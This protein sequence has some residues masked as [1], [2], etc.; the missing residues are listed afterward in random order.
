LPDNSILDLLKKEIPPH[1]YQRYIRQ[2]K[3]NEEDSSFEIAIF[4]A[5]NP[6]ISSWVKTKYAQKISHLFE[7]ANGIKP[8]VVIETKSYSP[9]LRKSSEQSVK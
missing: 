5:P 7:I 2:L 4:I 3:Y 1:E 6:L 9:S 8:E